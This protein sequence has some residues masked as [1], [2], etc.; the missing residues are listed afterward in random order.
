MAA[1][2]TGDVSLIQD[3]DVLRKMWQDT[4]DFG[5]KKEI[6]SHMY[7]IRE[8]RLKD[9]YNTGEELTSSS[10]NKQHSSSSTIR[11]TSHSTTTGLKGSD[12]T[13]YADNLADHSFLSLKSK[14]IR[15]SES[16][17][18]DSY[19]I[20][21]ET[22]K[23]NDRDWNV[24][25]SNEA[26]QDGKTHTTSRIATTSGRQDLEGGEMKYAAKSEQKAS[27]F[28]DGD[29]KNFTKSV[30]ASSQNVI[31]QEAK[32]GDD[33]SKY[34]SSSTTTTSSS[35]FSNEQRS[36]SDD[37]K[38]YEPITTTNVQEF[39]GQPSRNTR[40]IVRKVYTEDIPNQTKIIDP[41][42]KVTTETHTLPDGS[43]VT[44]TR[45][46]T[47]GSTQYKTSS[48]S[49]SSTKQKQ[50]GS[51]TEQK[52]TSNVV[53]SHVVTADDD[54]R[55]T[56]SDSISSRKETHH[57]ESDIRRMQDLELLGRDA[58]NVEIIVKN[59]TIPHEQARTVTTT[60]VT[61]TVSSDY[62]QQIP[63]KDGK[64]TVTTTKTFT[65]PAD[66]EETKSTS[67]I[68]TKKITSNYDKQQVASTDFLDSERQHLTQTKTKTT[69]IEDVPLPARKEI[70]QTE[71][72]TIR[73]DLTPTKPKP[74][75]IPESY[76][77]PTETIEIEIIPIAKAEPKYEQPERR[78]PI[79]P[80]KGELEE[81][82]TPTEGQYDTTYRSDYVPRR[83]SVEVSPTHDAFA[84]SLR[85]ISPDRISK[86]GSVRSLRTTSTTSLRSSPDRHP[87]R[88]SRAS[89]SDSMKKTTKSPGPEVI[90][91]KR[92]SESPEKKT[93][94]II[95]KQTE[96]R[97]KDTITRKKKTDETDSST[98]T[99]KTRPVDKPRSRSVSPTSIAS[100]IEFI[101]HRTD[102]VTDL[103]VDD[104]T[105]LQRRHT[106][107]FDKPPLTDSTSPKKSQR[108]TDKSATL[109]LPA[110]SPTKESP[111]AI[112]TEKPRPK[113]IRR[114]DTYEERCKE[115]LGIGDTTKEVPKK[116]VGKS[117]QKSPE[118][119]TPHEEKPKVAK[120]TSSVQEFPSQIRKSPQKEPLEYYLAKPKDE[121]RSP[122]VQEFP[123]Q[124][125][126]SPQK[127]P[128]EPYPE[129][130]RRSSPSVQE[131]PSQIRKS[132][133]KEPIEPYPEKPRSD[134]IKPSVQEFPAQIRKTPQKDPIQSYPVKSKDDKRSPSVQEFP[135]QIRK[136]PQKEPVEPYP[137]KPKSEK[138]KSSV[139]EFPSQTRKSH[140][141]EPLE[142]YPEK[143]RDEKK[144]ASVHEFPSQTRKSPQK[145]PLEP[146]PEKSRDDKKAP[147][148]QKSR[149]DKKA[150][151]V[152]E[153][154]SQIRKSPQKEP[155]EAYP[156]K[157]KDVK[158]PSSIQE[159]PSQVKKSPQKEPVEPYP[160]KPKVDKSVPSVQEFP[161]Q[162]RKSPQ[163]EP[164]EPYPQKLKDDKKSSSVQEFPSQKIAT[165]RT[166]R[167]VSR[168]TSQKEPLEQYP[169][170]LPTQVK[171][172][173]ESIE[174]I[175]PVATLDYP[176]YYSDE[177]DSDLDHPLQKGPTKVSLDDLPTIKTDKV[178]LDDLTN[179]TV[180]KKPFKEIPEKVSLDDLHPKK[181]QKL[182]DNFITNEKI[183]TEVTLTKYKDESIHRLKGIPDVKTK[184]PKKITKKTTSETCVDSE[185]ETSTT[186]DEDVLE[187][188]E[189][190]T[191]IIEEI[192]KIK[193]P[194]KPSGIDD[195]EDQI[196]TD[197]TDDVDVTV[198]RITTTE[199]QQL[200]SPKKEETAPQK[201]T[202]P[203]NKTRP[204]SKPDVEDFITV[205]KAQL[206]ETESRMPVEEVVHS[207]KFV[208]EL[209]KKEEKTPTSPKIDKKDQPTT[210]KTPSEIKK[211]DT[212][213]KS[214]IDSRRIT[215]KEAISKQTTKKIQDD[216][217][218]IKTEYTDQFTTKIKD[219]RVTKPAT[220]KVSTRITLAPVK[221]P[222]SKKPAP[223]TTLH[224][225]VQ[226]MDSTTTKKGVNVIK[227]TQIDK[228]PS[229]KL[230]S[231]YTKKL[232]DQQPKSKFKMPE[233]KAQ[234]TRTTAPVTKPTTTAPA[235][236]HVVSTII[237]LKPKQ[238]PETVT[239]T[240]HKTTVTKTIIAPKSTK[241]TPL[242]APKPTKSKPALNGDISTEEEEDSDTENITIKTTRNQTGSVRTDK[243]K[244][245]I[246]TKSILIENAVADEREI[247]V[248]LKRSKSSREGTPD[249]IC[250]Y[251]VST[252]SDLGIPRYPDRV[253]EPD[254]AQHRLKP[255]RISDIPLDETKDV[256]NFERIVE[257]DKTMKTDVE[258]TDECLLSVNEKVSKFLSTAEQIT[259][260][261]LEAKPA[262]KVERPKLEVD[263]SLKE[264]ECLL[265]VSDKV[266]KF[267]ATA[268][269]LASSTT[270]ETIQTTNK[271]QRYKEERE[272]ILETRK[273][274]KETIQTTNKTQRYKEE[275]EEILET[276]KRKSPDHQLTSKSR[277][278]EVEPIRF[279][280]PERKPSDSYTRKPTEDVAQTRK[281]PVEDDTTPKTSR[282]LSKDDSKPVLSPTGRLRSTETIKKAK[283]LFENYGN[284][285]E[286]TRQKDILNRPSVF[287]GRR[288]KQSEEKVEKKDVRTKLI[289]DEH[290]LRRSPSPQLS[291]QKTIRSHSPEGETPHYML[292][293][294]RSVR[295]ND[296][297]SRK[298]NLDEDL[299]VT[300]VDRSRGTTPDRNVPH[301]MLPLDRSLRERSPHKDNVKQLEYIANRS[302]TT[303]H[304]DDE[305]GVTLRDRDSGRMVQTTSRKLST[306]SVDEKSIDVDVEEIFDLEYLVKLLEI[307][308]GYDIR[309][310]IRA[311]IRLIKRAI[312]DNT[313]ETLIVSRR[314]SPIK[315]I[316]STRIEK[317]ETSDYQTSYQRKTS[318][319]EFSTNTKSPS[320]VRSQREPSPK[321]PQDRKSR[322]PE[323]DVVRS[324]TTT[325]TRIFQTDLKKPKTVTKTVTEE[326][327]EWVTQRTLRKVSETAPIKKTVTSTTTTTTH[328]SSTK[329][330]P[331]DDIT[332]S[333]GVGPTDEN[334]TPLF[335]LKA[336]RAQ[337]KSEKTKVQGTVIRS[338]F[339][340]ENGEEPEGEISV[341][342][343]S[344]D[345][346]DLGRENVI[347]DKG[348]ASVTTTQKFGYKGTPSLKTITNKSKKTSSNEDAEY[349]TSSVKVSKIARK[350]SV[351]EISQKF[352]DNAVESLKSERQSSY[353]KA[354]LILRTSSFKDSPS[355]GVD[356]NRS[357]EGSPDAQE[358]HEKV[359]TSVRETTSTTS[360]GKKSDTFLS[361]KSK[362][363][364]VHDVLSRMKNEAE[365]EVEE[366][367]EDAEARNLLNKFIGSQVLLSGM[368]S[369]LSKLPDTSPVGSV[370][371]TTKITTTTTSS[372]S[373]KPS[374]VTCTFT[375]P[376]TV[377]LLQNIWDEQTLKLLLEQSTDY[378]DRRII[379]TRLREV[380]AE[381]EA[382]AELV[383]KATSE[384]TSISKETGNTVH[385]ESLLL[386]LLQGL[387]DQPDNDQPADSGT[388]SGEDLRSGLIVEVQTAL[389][390]LANSLKSPSTNITEE[391][392]DSL[393][394]LVNRLQAGLSTSQLSNSS[395]SSSV[396][397]SERR[398]S[399]QGRFSKRKQ[400]AN[401]HTVGVS[402][403]ELEDAR[404]LMEEIAFHGNL[405][406]SG[407]Q[408]Q[409]SEGSV[410][411]TPPF[412]PLSK[413]KPVKNVTAK[414]F[415]NTNAVSQSGTSSTIDT[416]SETSESLEFL[417]SKEHIHPQ[418]HHSLSLDTPQIN[419]KQ[420]R[421]QLTETMSLDCTNRDNPTSVDLISIQKA[422]TQA[423]AIK[424]LSQMKFDVSDG[425]TNRAD[426]SE[427]GEE[428]EDEDD[429]DD[430]ATVKTALHNETRSSPEQ[431]GQHIQ[432]PQ[433]DLIMQTNPLYNRP[434]E[435]RDTTNNN[436]ENDDY[437]T[438]LNE[439]ANRFN[440]K[441]LK[442]KRAN[443]IDIPKPL[444]YYE[445][446][447]DDSDNENLSSRRN[448]YLALRGPIRV[449]KLNVEKKVPE[450]QPKTESDKKF[451]AF[452]GKHADNASNNNNSNNNNKT[453]LW[454]NQQSTINN[455]AKN[456]NNWSNKF[457]NIKNN[458]EKIQTSNS[459]NSARN[460][461]KSAD[462]AVMAGRAPQFGPK[463]SRQSAKNLQ[464]MFEEKQKQNQAN[465]NQS[466]VVTG[467]LKVDTSKTNKNVTVV[468][469]PNAINKFSHAPMSAFKPVAKKLEFLQHQPQQ[470]N[471]L[472][473]NQPQ[474]SSYI[475]PKPL[476]IAPMNTQPTDN[477]K[478]TIKPPDSPLYLYSPK[479]VSPQTTSPTNSAPW[480]SEK[481]SGESPLYLYSPKQVSPQTTS[482]TNSAPWNSEKNSGET[483]PPCSRVLSIAAA[484]FQNINQDRDSAP[485]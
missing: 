75:S 337:N 221:Q 243:K 259:K 257:I 468:T 360:G 354:G 95:N 84:R 18:K 216:H 230:P 200:K 448:S 246:T 197:E 299:G 256:H 114:T 433:P 329:K 97:N 477:N 469:Q 438:Q 28:K 277:T 162:I 122:S 306:S 376:I 45:Y 406:P 303:T 67:T 39:D 430:Q 33:N 409:N 5:K 80:H 457:G 29:D 364:G 466:N 397:S 150:P 70:T 386:P 175:E 440:S 404:R 419:N 232:D 198:R 102:L 471:H 188:T 271:T 127:E 309:R 370:K 479:Q 454:C 278:P 85:S 450:F 445:D 334:G 324:T 332:S 478:N 209:C 52:A 346:K 120:K 171:K 140:Q 281:Q 343:F 161:S 316:T 213:I 423:A 23:L 121:K 485:P 307:I 318:A 412:K 276:R 405:N 159:F 358:I 173:T 149:D 395:T 389:D 182:V 274:L 288:T 172:P 143:P 40:T 53:K 71:T 12:L 331:T 124:I 392:R 108:I 227:L 211:K 414:P 270:K 78:Q 385:G 345:P 411:E 66:Q 465:Q 160:E 415:F 473:Q 436:S 294:D 301:Y 296:N 351:K 147:S 380:M 130:P 302:I 241:S 321:K 338:Q 383:E 252:D 193:K 201:K 417:V 22:K 314:R 26:S 165:K 390:K 8:A 266:N 192:H 135:S 328:K 187:A 269:Q 170:K 191:E 146:Y 367:E 24:V 239:K 133:Q 350:G 336:L 447:D 194:I 117:P 304:S 298:E 315:E 37:A 249:Q 444:N 320:P 42:T 455:N 426:D 212:T 459:V 369:Q 378:E 185:T 113:S 333:Y 341:T 30:Q 31:K 41:N 218:T 59:Q 38:H 189:D 81:R 131:F 365:I 141:K 413:I 434:S 267:I 377:E 381:Q 393:L 134:K 238:K 126:K 236:R 208:R 224:F 183:D 435:E 98:L 106:Q 391:R 21:T 325:S 157:L 312:E 36:S 178:S 88:V 399:L 245:C 311:Q 344:T 368:E 357:R 396:S 363:T 154:P 138:I 136:S 65:I 300:E 272:E 16:P 205:T 254:D 407:L 100:D 17:T 96:E 285:R 428:T 446:D 231:T 403:E 279:K 86:T 401:R 388:E 94:R 410:L 470:Q 103:D 342:K 371:H 226:K 142:P 441:K 35:K 394:Q 461:W 199:S 210:S 74:E 57:N 15:D 214:R 13:T 69:T 424:Q 25:E 7:K 110:K 349:K 79:K 115:I 340:S 73:K 46:E 14:E 51:S 467:H 177:N 313:L 420:K 129:K 137:H 203:P 27:V 169:E 219:K 387:L 104:I 139:Q 196:I 118:K 62:D 476:R 3:E 237:N 93:Q 125:R 353:P 166:A 374:S 258:S 408:K 431:N 50:V 432:Q 112:Q 1:E 482:P 322:T 293:L 481:N 128:I 217:Y 195:I 244:K 247:I 6:R 58:K 19:K 310:R 90:P 242:R 72:V 484:K 2:T 356:L 472:Q 56:R 153:F 223:D 287:E 215:P 439:K 261:P 9:F 317:R 372:D 458:F 11:T 235:K 463:I 174:S 179:I 480:N 373:S 206:Q 233:T 283:A 348:V 145:Q 284:E 384:D 379:R 290:Q 453:S 323:R 119:Q 4:D 362:V 464:Q 156:E 347:A 319:S 99:R 460:F 225:K 474:Y 105:K 228:K 151:S 87:N 263:E 207:K 330:Q 48:S 475:K 280:T 282:R 167:T 326:K 61:K 255:K 111:P 416:P 382:C 398:S 352:L 76:P 43:T 327:P 289:Y 123:S 402:S 418:F 68:I 180:T 176:R 442:M 251:P 456:S 273:S 20:I 366:T 54:N 234:P 32:G 107:E 190:K 425:V 89:P 248:D 82:P 262:P 339:Y 47:K 202:S 451:M 77:R 83:I 163:K 144:P 155:L 483:A 132:P 60:S 275:R 250:P 253:T 222:E 220:T 49:S 268:E 297:R 429:D 375:H 335:G 308:V 10:E 264:D 260:K 421:P 92:M 34:Y 63:I 265:S 44:T 422:V 101:R 292:P 91:K 427:S 148:V 116:P 158:R 109:P 359:V 168:K 452:L 286:V 295:E 437:P 291:K 240:I 400:R 449:G 164:L 443:T 462:D 229:A 181:S 361:N 204:K 186:E 152:Q 355:N 64:T 305:F 184:K 55:S